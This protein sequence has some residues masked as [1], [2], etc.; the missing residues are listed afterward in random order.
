MAIV[1]TI[2][3]GKG[4]VGK[5]T[6]CAGLGAALAQ[7]GERVLLIDGDA[8][9]RSLDLLLGVTEALV[10]DLGDVVERRCRPLEA[11]YPSVVPGLSLLSAQPG[12]PFAPRVMRAVVDSLSP[13]FDRILIDGPAGIGA[14]FLSATAP[15]QSVILVAT[16]D[17]VCVRGTAIVRRTLAELGL[18]NCR[19]V[20]NRFRAGAFRRA[21]AFADLD[22][23]ID[24]AGVQLLGIVCEDEAIARGAAK[25]HPPEGASPAAKAFRRI[26]RRL[27]GERVELVVD[28]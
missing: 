24:R 15:A 3:S 22:E 5:S 7:M 6:L 10:Y 17:A 12:R 20:L 2:A 11:V 8:G 4:G 28:D 14:G 21:G 27:R 23:L 25:G 1:T 13:R 16:A 9:L 26:A 19:L 18:E